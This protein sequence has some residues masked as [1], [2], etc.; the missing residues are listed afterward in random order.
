MFSKTKLALALTALGA[1]LCALPSV[2]EAK[3]ARCEISG[4]GDDSYAAGSHYQGPCDFQAKK[5]GSFFVQL[6]DAANDSIGATAFWVDIKAPGI[7]SLSGMLGLGGRTVKF[8]TTKRS[9]QETAC[10]IGSGWK[11]CVY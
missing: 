1:C 9:S 10:W 3:T 11:I 7:G 8:G 5:G 6:P 4:V 2:A